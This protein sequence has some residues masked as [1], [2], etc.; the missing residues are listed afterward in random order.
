MHRCWISRGT[1]AVL[2]AA[3]A[4]GAVSLVPASAS[5]HANR[6]VKS[7]KLTV[8]GAS[9]ATLKGAKGQ[10]Y[11]SR[12]GY[13]I[14]FDAKDYPG[15]GPDGSLASAGPGPATPRAK[16]ATYSAFTARIDGARYVLDDTDG[17]KA[18]SDAVTL[19]IKRKSI[20]FDE[21]PIIEFETQAHATMTGIVK[22]KAAA[23]H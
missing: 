15:L 16:R 18:V 21:Y 11:I 17:L 20:K 4:L 22:C 8:T 23:L 14:D 12:D 9:T 1:G 7:V 13:N 10:C 5:V 3:I 6:Y 19:N 2:V